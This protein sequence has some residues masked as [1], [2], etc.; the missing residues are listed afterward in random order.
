[1]ITFPLDAL[2]AMDPLPG[3]KRAKRIVAHTSF[4]RVRHMHRPYVRLRRQ[5]EPALKHDQDFVPIDQNIRG[6]NK[7]TFRKLFQGSNDTLRIYKEFYIP[8]QSSSIHFLRTKLS[9]TGRRA[10][11]FR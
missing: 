5:D 11:E 9:Y 8:V 1:M 3:P 4:F 10:H 7:P 2:E 6:R